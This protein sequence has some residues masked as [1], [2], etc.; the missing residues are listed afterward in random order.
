MMM[1]DLYFWGLGLLIGV[2][3][4]FLRGVMERVKELEKY[5]VMKG[6]ELDILKN[7][8]MNKYENLTEKFDELK[9][10]IMELTR[11]MKELVKKINNK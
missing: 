7:D 8:H 4:Y 2:V 3:G 9:N 5:T 11:E 1:N 10:V 6:T